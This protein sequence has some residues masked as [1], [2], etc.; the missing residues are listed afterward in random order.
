MKNVKKGIRNLVTCLIAI[1]AI[2]LIPANTVE[3]STKVKIPGTNIV[4]D[5]PDGASSYHY[6]YTKTT[7]KI[8]VNGSTKYYTYDDKGN[9][10]E[11]DKDGNILNNK[12]KDKNKS[13]KTKTIK[14]GWIKTAKGKV[15]YKNGKKVTGIQK[16]GKKT[17]YFDKKGIMQ[18]NKIIKVNGKIY[19][20][21]KKGHMVKKNSYTGKLNG[22]KVTYYFGDDGVAIWKAV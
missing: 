5:V 9:L 22:K 10:V 8:T 7:I 16:I 13:D 21:D 11:T 14:K 4:I 12:D 19:A 20:F 3:A 2:M 17:Y 18:K 15:Y 1:F 6:E